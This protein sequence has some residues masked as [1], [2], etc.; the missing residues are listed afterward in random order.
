M[1]NLGFVIAG[2]LVKKI[3]TILKMVSKVVLQKGKENLVT[4]N[5]KKIELMLFSKIRL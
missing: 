5:I 2:S 4:Y 1:D 3:V